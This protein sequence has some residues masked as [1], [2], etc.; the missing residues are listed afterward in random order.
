[1]RVRAPTS[2]V[3]PSASWR[4]TT[5]ARVARHALRRFRGNARAAFHDGL[6]R[7][8]G[9][10]QDIGIDVDD[11]LVALAR[12]AGVDPVVERGLGDQRQRI[13][14]LLSE[15]SAFPRERPPA[16]ERRICA[17]L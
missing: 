2:I 4:I 7:R 12:S 3:R 13:S 9:V 6:A 10:G 14:L 8:I 15:R 11:D 1:M 17:R 16:C 5:P